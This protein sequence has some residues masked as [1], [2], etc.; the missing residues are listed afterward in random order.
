MESHGYALDEKA[1][2]DYVTKLTMAVDWGR[3]IPANGYYKDNAVQIEEYWR[4]RWFWQ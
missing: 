2:N 3:E 4:R 1:V